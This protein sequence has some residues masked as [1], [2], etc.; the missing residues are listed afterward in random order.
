MGVLMRNGLTGAGDGGAPRRALPRLRVEGGRFIDADGRQVMLRGVNLGGD[1]KAPYP[2]GGTDRPSDFSDH[3]SVSFTGRPFPIAEADEH[4]ARLAHWGFNCLRLLTTWEAVE[5][6]G[7]GLYDEQYLDYYAQVCRKAGEHGLYVFVDFHQDV[8]SRMSGGDGAPGW[9][10]EAL[11]LDLTRFPRAGAA[12]VMQAEYDYRSEVRRQAAYPQMTWASNYVR[13]VNGIMWSLFWGGRVLTPDF[14]VDGR[15]VQDFLQGS[16]LA[17]MNAMAERLA[18]IPNVIGFDTLNEPGAGWIGKPLAHRRL[19]PTAE[20]PTPVR[21]GL[22]WSPLDGLACARGLS[23]RLPVLKRDPVTS[24]TS[25]DGET[26][27]NADRVSIWRD[28]RC[29]FEAAGAYSVEGLVAR[30]GPDDFFQR[31]KLDAALGAFFCAVGDIIRAHRQDWAVFAE[32][33]AYSAFL[34][35]GFPEG[36]PARTVN[37]N[38]WYDLVTLVTK[39]FQP[40]HEGAESLARTATRYREQLSRYAEVSAAIPGGAPTL[41]GEF[42]IPY[43]LDGGEAFARWAAGERGEELWRTHGTALSAMYDILDDLL[44]HST[45]WNYTASNRNDLRIGDGW[46]QED[47]SIFSRDQQED[48]ADLDSG[49]RAIDGF[50]RP[51]VRRAQGRLTFVRFSAVSGVLDAKVEV[52]AAVDAPTEIYWPAR[53]FPGQPEVTV[54]GQSATDCRFDAASQTISLRGLSGHAAI[55]VVRA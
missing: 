45:Q 17:A 18:A 9:V 2:D 22:V 53:R 26:I 55:R 21:A 46:N 4:L 54:D 38:H 23:V 13:P 31:V 10:F 28:G 35:E 24:L 25:P 37:A 19:T 39:S 49:G 48:R 51:Y 47:L 16:Y 12:H 52:D 11:G 43:D 27:L 8:W 41:I 1:C 7:P 15:N 50:C 40:A 42:G 20:D 44:F 33:E 32:I 14:V 6:A 5:H 36:V 30:P 34:G 29:P 3:R